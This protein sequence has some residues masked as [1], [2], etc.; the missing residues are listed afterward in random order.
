MGRKRCFEGAVGCDGKAAYRADRPAAGGEVGDGV[1]ARTTREHAAAQCRGEAGCLPVGEVVEQNEM[2][3]A[4]HGYVAFFYRYSR[5]DMPVKTS[6]A[7]AVSS[8]A[9]RA[10]ILA[11]TSSSVS[12]VPWVSRLFPAPSM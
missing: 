4:L 9:V 2:D 7:A 12:I 3:G 5:R 1:G 6:S 11:Q 10:R 8:E